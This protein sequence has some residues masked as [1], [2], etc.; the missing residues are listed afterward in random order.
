MISPRWR[1]RSSE[2]GSRFGRRRLCAAGPH[3][4]ACWQLWRDLLHSSDSLLRSARESRPGAFAAAPAAC[5]ELAEGPAGCAGGILPPGRV[6]LGAGLPSAHPTPRRCPHAG[7][8]P[9]SPLTAAAS[10]HTM[11]VRMARKRRSSEVPASGAEAE[12]LGSARPTTSTMRPAGRLWPSIR[13]SRPSNMCTTER[14]HAGVAELL[15]QYGSR[16]R[17]RF[18]G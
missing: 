2:R 15:R 17:E 1:A 14:E 3:L 8:R 13:P 4:T 10:P 12:C 6:V 11:A 9:H 7:N 18:D 16:E 5:P